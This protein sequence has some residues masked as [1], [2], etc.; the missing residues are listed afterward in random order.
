MTRI[1]EAVILARGLGTR[2][3]ATGA[4]LDAAT[5]AVADSG[6]KALIPID[7]PFLDYV[8]HDLAEAGITRVVLVIGPEH[9][10]L[11]RYCAELKAHRI[12]L[13]TAIQQRPLGT[14][15]AV[16]AAEGQVTGGFLVING[17][18][19]YPASA[20]HDLA[21]LGIPGLVGFRRSGLITGNI[22]ADRITRFAMIVSSRSGADSRLQAI[23][24]KPTAAQLADGGSDPL[25]SMNCWSFDRTIFAACRRIVPSSRGEL[26]LPDAVTASMTT[27]TCYRIVTSHEAVL[28]LSSREDIA[29]VRHAL[30]GA[31]VRL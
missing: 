27:G 15:D 12:R 20:L 5:A 17:D 4:T 23:I 21:E 8:L 10:A 7:R 25:L 30:L 24:E 14:A 2:M 31:M 6:V 29:T 11:R 22:P 1:T 28:D 26:E 19:R 9:D 3:R 13:V 18:N 16:L